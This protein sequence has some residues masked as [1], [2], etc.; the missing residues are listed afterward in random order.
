MYLKKRPPHSARSTKSKN[1]FRSPISWRRFTFRKNHKEWIIEK[2]TQY[3]T[4][5]PPFQNFSILPKKGL[6]YEDQLTEAINQD[7][8]LRSRQ[9]EHWETTCGQGCIIYIYIYIYTYNN[10]NIN[11][12]NWNSSKILNYIYVVYWKLCIVYA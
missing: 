8:K 9:K 6:R 12:N 4:S 1:T 3:T 10:I 5:P 2:S 7:F 11:R